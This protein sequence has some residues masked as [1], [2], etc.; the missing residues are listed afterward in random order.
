[1]MEMGD[2]ILDRISFGRIKE[3]EEIYSGA[4]GD[5]DG[6]QMTAL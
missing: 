2:T 1:M 4:L 6:P 3:L 5:S